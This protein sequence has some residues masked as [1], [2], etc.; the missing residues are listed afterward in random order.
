MTVTGRSLLVKAAK[1]YDLVVMSCSFGL[2]SVLVA[3]QTTSGFADFFSMRV[4]VRNFILFAA[5]LIIWHNV[6]VLF[7]LYDS[8]RLSA[9]TREVFDVFKATTIGAGAVYLAALAFKLVMVTPV[10][11]IDLWLISSA[12]MVVS[13]LLARYALFQ[14]RLHNRNL[15]TMLIV[16]TN[17]R[18]VLFAQS[19]ETR[20]TRGYRVLG[21]ADQDWEGLQEFRKGE[22]PL[23]SDF[24]KFPFFLRERAVDEVLIALPMRS[25]Y[26][27]ASRIVDLCE[28]Q[29]VTVRLLPDLFDLPFSQSKAGAPDEFPMITLCAHSAESWQH[30]AKRVFDCAVSLLAIFL[31][32]PLF[33]LTALLVKLSSSGPVFFIQERVGLNKRRFRLYKFRTMVVDAESRLSEIESLNEAHGPVFKIKNDPRLTRLGRFLRKSSIDELPQLFNVLKGEMSLVGPRP[34]PVRDYQGFAQDWQRRRFSV[35]PGITCLW[36]VNGRSSIPFD[37]WMELDMQYID[38]WSL[39]LDLKILV[40]TIPAVIKGVGAA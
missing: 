15:R 40:K 18:A 5:L 7:G 28:E 21:F 27:Q 3:Q 38:Q 8:R 19:I 10:F 31:F 29:G 37:K 30:L 32:S 22:Y 36:Q 17:P 13:R 33:L 23:S 26:L 39:R 9:I 25:M 1:L 6:F 16:G 20:P 2:A 12:V 11:L 14:A 4:K 35:R 24:E 34:L